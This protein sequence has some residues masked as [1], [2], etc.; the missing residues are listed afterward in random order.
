MAANACGSTTAIVDGRA[1]ATTRVMVLGAATDDRWQTRNFG[2]SAPSRRRLSR[3]IRHHAPA[4]VV[5]AGVIDAFAFDLDEHRW[6]VQVAAVIGAEHHREIRT[7]AFP[8]G[9]E[10][11]PERY[12]GR[13]LRS[14]NFDD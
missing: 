1:A 2:R 8:G 4:Y 9:F 12:F 10:I 11:R 13:A 7:L 6:S 5:D 3:Q 14:A